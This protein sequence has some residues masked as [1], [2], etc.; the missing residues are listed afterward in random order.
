MDNTDQDRDEDC[1][2]EEAGNDDMDRI[3]AGGV[4]RRILALADA[5]KGAQDRLHG[6]GERSLAWRIFGGSRHFSGAL[7]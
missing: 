5:D 6:G 2:A 4:T 3:Q 1:H 7:S